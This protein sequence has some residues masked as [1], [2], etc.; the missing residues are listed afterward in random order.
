MDTMIYR[1][2]FISNIYGPNGTFY[3]SHDEKAAIIW[4]SYKER[5]GKF[6]NPTMLFDLS[7]IVQTHNLTPPG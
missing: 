6:N 3:S 5:V 1:K 2:N 4:Q 7:E